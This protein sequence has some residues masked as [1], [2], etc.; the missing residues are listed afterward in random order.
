MWPCCQHG[1]RRLTFGGDGAS[2]PGRRETPALGRVGC[3]SSLPAVL[4]PVRRGPASFLDTGPDPAGAHGRPAHSSWRRA[5][6]GS[7]GARR[8]SSAPAPC[9]PTGALRDSDAASG[10]ESGLSDS[11]SEPAAP[12]QVH[13]GDPW[14]LGFPRRNFPDVGRFS[15]ICCRVSNWRSLGHKRQ[16]VYSA[17][18]KYRSISGRLRRPRSESFPGAAHAPCW[19]REQLQYFIETILCLVRSQTDAETLLCSPC[20]QLGGARYHASCRERRAF[21]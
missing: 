16:L 11:G 14:L 19:R 18:S 12:I 7:V 2:D 10:G 13:T 1:I 5:T 8:T 17:I 9:R 20:L 4:R 3:V 6:A 21:L 15:E